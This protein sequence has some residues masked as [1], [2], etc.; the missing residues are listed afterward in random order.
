ML[1]KRII[2][3][4]DVRNDGQVVKGIQFKNLKSAGEPIQLAKKYYE[5][6]IDELVFLDINTNDDKRD[7]MID[8]IQ[9]VAQ[10]IFIPFTVGGGIRT[11]GDVKKIL[12]AGADKVS[13]NRAAIT[14]PT[15]ISQ[16]A[17]MFGSQAIVV[18]IDAKKS[19]SSWNA[20]IG[21]G[22]IDTGKNA[23]EWAIEA[24]A[25][26]AGEILLTSIDS[27][28]TRNGFEIELTRNISQKVSVPVIASGGAGCSGDFFDVFSKGF[29]D[30]ALAASLFHF[31]NVKIAE[32]KKYLAKLQIPIR[33]K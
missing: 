22:K 32:L 30:G 25:R 5:Q 10:E 28:G 23:V 13:L 26:G 2:A 21:G 3:C 12:R 16:A 27:D 4:L 7:Y 9:K 29:A 33:T 15:L 19:G 18:A 1:T 14:N 24:V 8:V 6:G 11:L 20:F 31:D 17:G